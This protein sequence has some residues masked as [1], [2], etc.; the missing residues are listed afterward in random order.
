V[1]SQM[2]VVGATDHG[3][4][5]GHRVVSSLMQRE[6]VTPP[7]RSQEELPALPRTLTSMVGQREHHCVATP[8]FEVDTIQTLI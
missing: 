5:R 4:T 6:V 7:Q 8:P 2:A 1:A 3:G